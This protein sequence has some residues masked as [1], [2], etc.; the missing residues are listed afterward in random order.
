MRETTFDHLS[1]FDNS[2]FVKT[3][4]IVSCHSKDPY[5]FSASVTLLLSSISVAMVNNQTC[6]WKRDLCTGIV[7]Q[8][9]SVNV[10]LR[11]ANQLFI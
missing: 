11:T 4:S 3:R 9:G 6:R 10:E 1:Y 2:V 5:K 7:W 8:K